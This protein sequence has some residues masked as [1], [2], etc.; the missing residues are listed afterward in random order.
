VAA[1]WGL[2]SRTATRHV[3]AET[4]WTVRQ[5]VQAARMREAA[6]ALASTGDQVAQ[7]A[8]ALGY[9]HPTQFDRDFRRAL[10]VAPKEFRR[11]LEGAWPRPSEDSGQS[12][13]NAG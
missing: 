1:T 7:I 11:L 2:A 4:G 6:R 12:A 10:G 8:Y 13:R 3:Q 9:H 5:W